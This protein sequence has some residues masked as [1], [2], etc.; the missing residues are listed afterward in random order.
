MDNSENFIE[1]FVDNPN[2]LFFS[3]TSVTQLEFI[4]LL[5]LFLGLC[6]D[7][8]IRSFGTMDTL[9][10]ALGMNKDAMVDTLFEMVSKKN[11]NIVTITS[12]NTFN[13]DVIE[14]AVTI[15]YYLETSCKDTLTQSLQD[16]Q[17]TI[18]TDV[19]SLRIVI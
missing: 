14:N 19:V 13:K 3:I 9:S 18:S 6:S 5:D 2:M 17:F 7:G 15:T 11:K 1:T 10:N 4:Y 12:K 8:V 16:S